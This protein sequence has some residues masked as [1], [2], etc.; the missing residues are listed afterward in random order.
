MTLIE[1][2]ASDYPSDANLRKTG[3]A[4]CGDLVDERDDASG[5]VLT[6]VWQPEEEWQGGTL[7]GWCWTH[8]KTGLLPAR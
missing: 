7:Y 3:Q 8:S 5:L 6:P 1:R 4:M 2:D